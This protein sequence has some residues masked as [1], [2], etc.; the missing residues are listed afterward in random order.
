[1][2][3]LKDIEH[4]IAQLPEEQ[5]R[6]VVDWLSNY[7]ELHWDHPGVAGLEITGLED[8]FHV[9]DAQKLNARRLN[10]QNLDAQEA[11]ASELAHLI[12]Q[13]HL[14]LDVGRFSQMR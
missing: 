2:T 11:L 3:S 8:G 10:A 7:F 6:Q 14:Q 12:Q 13:S 9:S 4:A 1:M 5:I